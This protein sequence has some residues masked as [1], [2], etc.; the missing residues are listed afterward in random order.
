MFEFTARLIDHTPTTAGPS[1]RF[2]VPR[3]GHCSVS[4]GCGWPA[5]DADDVPA[6]DAHV[7][8]VNAP[9]PL[10]PSTRVGANPFTTP[11]TPEVLDDYYPHPV[12][13]EHRL[14][15]TCGNCGATCVQVFLVHLT[16]ETG[17][18]ASCIGKRA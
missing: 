16:A 9:A 12:V 5:I 14:Y 13:D 18:C 6:P 11:P 2:P 7:G 17:E 15:G 1:V 10:P 8:C 4:V 3:H